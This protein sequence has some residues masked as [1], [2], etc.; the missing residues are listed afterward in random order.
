MFLKCC[1]FVNHLSHFL[2]NIGSKREKDREDICV[3]FPLFR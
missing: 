3:T 1:M 2:H